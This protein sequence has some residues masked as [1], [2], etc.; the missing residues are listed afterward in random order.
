[1]IFIRTGLIV[2]ISTIFCLC[3]SCG[4]TVPTPFADN[5]T[6]PTVVTN[7]LIQEDFESGYAAWKATGSGFVNTISSGRS[8]TIGLNIATVFTPSTTILNRYIAVDTNMH[9]ILSGYMK[10]LNQ[11]ET[12]VIGMQYVDANSN[13]ISSTAVYAGTTNYYEYEQRRMVLSP[14]N[15][16]QA[17]YLNVYLMLQYS[18]GVNKAVKFDDIVLVGY[19]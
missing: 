17:K 15:V 11:P 12:H 19:K 6:G 8:G 10:P 14:K 3:I 2:L 13:A 9:Y 16:P 18:A 7:T 4:S 5:N 1:M